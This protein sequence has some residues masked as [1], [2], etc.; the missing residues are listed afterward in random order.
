VRAVPPGAIGAVAAFAAGRDAV[1]HA[2]VSEQ[3]QENAECIAAHG[4]TPVHVLHDAGALSPLFTAVHATHVSVGDIEMLASCRSRCCICPTTERDLADGIGPTAALAAAGVG[5]CLGSDAHAVIDPFEEA[6]AVELNQRLATLRRGA[7]QPADL[8]TAATAAGYDSLGWSGGGRLAIGAP[9]DFVTLS[10]A[11][12]RLAGADRRTDP[13]A[14]VVF[15]AAAGDVSD[16]VVAGE[17]V[18]RAGVHQRVDVPAALASSI[19]A[20]WTRR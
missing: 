2:H 15:G 18:V 7:H 12:P 13:L 16:V 14:A 17:H 6:R 10:F 1:V 3:P 20:A 9:A 5:L 11:G 8:L 19:A 4:V